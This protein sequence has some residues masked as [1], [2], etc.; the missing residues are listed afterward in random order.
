MGPEDKTCRNAATVCRAF[1][2]SRRRDVLSFKH[3]AVLAPLNYKPELV[4]ELLDW[5]EAPKVKAAVRGLR[6]I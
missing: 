4:D 3:H 1:E 5:C 2:T 6:R